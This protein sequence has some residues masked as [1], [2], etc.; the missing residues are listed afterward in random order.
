[1]SEPVTEDRVREI[2]REEMDRRRAETREQM[3][4]SL[5]TWREKRLAAAAETPVPGEVAPAHRAAVADR[6]GRGS[7]DDPTT[8]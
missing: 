7:A 5:R 2:V 4:N 8:S 6:D 1:M 3:H